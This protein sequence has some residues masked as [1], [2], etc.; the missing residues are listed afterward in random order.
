[1]QNYSVP[2]NLHEK[3]PFNPNPLKVPNEYNTVGSYV[4]TFEINDSWNRRD[5]FIH[6]SSDRSAFYVWLDG[7]FV[8]YIGNFC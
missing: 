1:M 4:K 8:G 3:Y 6:F 2:I 7:V 5:V